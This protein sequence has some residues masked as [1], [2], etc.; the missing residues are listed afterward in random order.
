MSESSIKIV[1]CNALTCSANSKKKAHKKNIPAS[2]LANFPHHIL[3][4]HIRKEFFLQ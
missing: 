1:S 3:L 2:K 4:C